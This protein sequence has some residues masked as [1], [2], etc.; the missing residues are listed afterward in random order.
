M[1]CERCGACIC[2]EVAVGSQRHP[3]YLFSDLDVLVSIL[4]CAL[5]GCAA[6]WLRGRPDTIV[7]VLCGLLG[8]IV[9]YAVCFRCPD[10]DSGSDADEDDG[11]VGPW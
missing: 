4:V 6:Y 11:G 7:V 5:G 1:V 8:A 3:R 9:L 2:D 10:R